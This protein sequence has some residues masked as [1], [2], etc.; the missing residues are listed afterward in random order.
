M[1]CWIAQ[2]D[3]KKKTAEID[4]GALRAHE[5]KRKR[6]EEMFGRLTTTTKEEDP[7]PNLHST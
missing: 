5:A 1:V 7:T 6:A 4:E 2:F 3:V